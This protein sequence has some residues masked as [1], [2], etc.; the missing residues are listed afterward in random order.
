MRAVALTAFALTLFGAPAAIAQTPQKAPPRPTEVSRS[1]KSDEK[2]VWTKGKRL[3]A[4]QRKHRSYE[5][6]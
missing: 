3:S 2:P 1:H 6:R 4:A 5:Q